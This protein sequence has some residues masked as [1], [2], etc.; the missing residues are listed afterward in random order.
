MKVQSDWK[1]GP[2][3]RKEEW[4]FVFMSSGALCVMTHGEWLMLLWCA[5]KWAT[6]NTVS[7]FIT[8]MGVNW[9]LELAK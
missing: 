8:C 5:N 1:E 3:Q 6:Q 7:L 4:K 2:L 9:F